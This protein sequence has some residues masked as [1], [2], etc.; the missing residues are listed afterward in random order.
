MKCHGSLFH[1]N[2]TVRTDRC[3][4][5]IIHL[6]GSEC[7]LGN[8]TVCGCQTPWKRLT[9][10]MSLFQF[11]FFLE[12]C[13][14]VL[15]EVR[16]NLI[17]F[18]NNS[19][20]SDQNEHINMEGTYHLSSKLLRYMQEI[21]LI[22]R[23]HGRKRPIQSTASTFKPSVHRLIMQTSFISFVHL[24]FK[25][26]SHSQVKYEE[27]SNLNKLNHKKPSPGER[28]HLMNCF[29]LEGMNVNFKSVL[30]WNYSLKAACNLVMSAHWE[31]L[32]VDA[33]LYVGQGNSQLQ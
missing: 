25:W 2:K 21:L 19:N 32:Y 5:N 10:Q 20:H 3:S 16:C 9:H 8:E 12:L 30:S 18:G 13:L 24:L 23:C 33:Q 4:L 26:N 31:T 28:M 29:L 1:V 11:Q 17:I 22:R 27:K 7:G 15:N 6:V 14:S